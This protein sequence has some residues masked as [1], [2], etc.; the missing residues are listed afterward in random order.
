VA[1]ADE[2]SRWFDV[3]VN[4][5]DVFIDTVIG[6]DTLSDLPRTGWLLRGVRPCESI[7]DHTFGVALCSLLL[8]DALRAEG[9]T[10]D[11]ERVLRMALVHDAPEAK[12]GDLP[13]PIKT[14]EI[15]SALDELD[16]RLA[17]GLLSESLYQAWAEAERGETIEAKI[18]KA[19]DKLQMMIKAY[20]YERQGRGR[21]DEFWDNPKNFRDMGL[22]MAKRIYARLRERAGRLATPGQNS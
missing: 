10:I 13:M 3:A 11:G 1:I 5:A 21:L 7:A 2:Q 19:S 16:A 8:T 20:I 12:T 9:E 15:E 17:R 4:D 22:P 18:V 14:A 6:L